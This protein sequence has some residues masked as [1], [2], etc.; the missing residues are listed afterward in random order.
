MGKAHSLHRIP[1]CP[2]VQAPVKEPTLG[3][4][5]SGNLSREFIQVPRT[6]VRVQTWRI[7]PTAETCGF[8][9]SHRHTGH[10]KISDRPKMV[11]WSLHQDGSVKDL[12]QTHLAATEFSVDHG[13]VM[14]SLLG[15]EGGCAM[16][17]QAQYLQQTQQKS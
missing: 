8:C 9:G 3:L 6:Q 5:E 2:I 15:P 1:Q 13:R 4:L 12:H 7:R 17:C 11:R 16:V 14:M 10:S